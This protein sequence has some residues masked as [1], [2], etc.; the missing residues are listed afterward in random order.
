[1]EIIDDIFTRCSDRLDKQLYFFENILGERETLSLVEDSLY[2]YVAGNILLLKPDGSDTSN[3]PE[4]LVESNEET[5]KRERKIILQYL[6][7]LIHF[8]AKE[9]HDEAFKACVKVLENTTRT[10]SR[11]FL[12]I[13]YLIVLFDGDELYGNL[14]GPLANYCANIIYNE[15]KRRGE[16]ENDD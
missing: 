10:F 5:Y 7:T 2:F 16:K 14:C 11:E 9:K 12:N 1:M 6:I 13:L 15:F 4:L 8:E 3:S